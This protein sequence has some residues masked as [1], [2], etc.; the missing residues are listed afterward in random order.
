MQCD[1]TLNN[2]DNEI[3]ALYIHEQ[4]FERPRLSALVKNVY[5][6]KLKAKNFAAYMY[7]GET[8]S[9]HSD[10]KYVE[11]GH[12][13]VFDDKKRPRDHFILGIESSFDESAASLVNSYGEVIQDHSITQWEQWNENDGVA[14][15]VAKE[16]HEKNIPEVIRKT[17]EGAGIK[18]GDPRFKAIAVTMGPGQE[19]SIN[20]GLK[21]AQELGKEY[22]VPV[23]PVN[24]IEGHIMVSAI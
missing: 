19:K 16:L 9:T 15:E 23:I 7:A 6:P 1:R 24:H 2:F 12:N 13:K 11:N 14:P 10:Y 20:V 22:G 17:L 3:R 5:I 21:K 4:N 18:K 8:G